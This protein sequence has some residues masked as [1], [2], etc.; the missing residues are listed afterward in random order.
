MAAVTGHQDVAELLIGKGADINAKSSCDWTPLLLAT[1]NGHT[2]L[3]EFLLKNDA[4]VNLMTPW[5]VKKWSFHASREDSGRGVWLS[6]QDNL[7]SFSEVGPIPIALAEQLV[8]KGPEGKTGKWPIGP[9]WVAKHTGNSEISELLQ[10]YG[11]LELSL[12]QAAAEGNITQVQLHISKGT[13][14]NEKHRG[15]TPL[16]YAE[17]NGHKEIVALLGEHGAMK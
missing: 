6:I 4:A 9:L 10:E 15:G 3:V 5:L 13:D 17:D 11:A 12:H 7:A 8:F 1:N 2:Q 16:S 14:V